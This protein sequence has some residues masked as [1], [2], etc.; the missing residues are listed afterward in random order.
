L[1]IN[2]TF[3]ISQ[4]GRLNDSNIILR[5]ILRGEEV[6]VDPALNPGDFPKNCYDQGLMMNFSDVFFPA[7]DF[8]F[9]ASS[10][11]AEESADTR[12]KDVVKPDNVNASEGK[13]KHRL[14]KRK[15]N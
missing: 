14:R 1:I 11:I 8:Y 10:S 13:K 2:S 4:A 7:S 6:E 3:D 12:R 15:V 5:K 9:E